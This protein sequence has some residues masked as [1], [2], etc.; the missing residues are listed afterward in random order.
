[1]VRCFEVFEHSQQLCTAAVL[2]QGMSGMYV[3]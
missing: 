1:M 3:R 2:E